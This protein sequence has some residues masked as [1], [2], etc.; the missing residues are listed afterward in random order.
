MRQFSVCENRDPAS[1][2]LY[3][4]LLNIQ[5]DLMAD[6]ETRVVAPLYPLGQGRNPSI[7]SLSPVLKLN[8]REYVLM[9]PLLAGVALARLGKP[10]ADLSGERATILAALDL[11]ISGI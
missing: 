7:S 8:G 4:L 11:L 6:A 5:S 1:R 10:V 2:K 3:P 9:T